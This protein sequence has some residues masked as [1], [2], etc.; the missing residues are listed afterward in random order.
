MEERWDPEEGR[1]VCISTQ[2]CFSKGH[3]IVCINDHG[4]LFP[5]CMDVCMHVAWMHQCIDDRYTHTCTWMQA[6]VHAWMH[7]R[8][9]WM[10]GCMH[11]RMHGWMHRRMHG[12]MHGSM[13]GCMHARM[14]ACIDAC[15][16]ARVD[17]CVEAYM[18]CVQGYIYV[19]IMHANTQEVLGQMV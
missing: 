17:A 11:R 5:E 9:A 6:C 15:R 16:N 8:H 13:H 10:H 7:C 2:T 14:L 3:S 19:R 4:K 12:W 1:M 18:S